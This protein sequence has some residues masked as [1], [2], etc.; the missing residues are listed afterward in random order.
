VFIRYPR[1]G[2]E[3]CSL[4]RSKLAIGLVH[5]VTL[6]VC[7]PNFTTMTFISS[8][9]SEVIAAAAD[10]CKTT[11][12]ENNTSSSSIANSNSAMGALHSV[13]WSFQRVTTG[14]G[15]DYNAN[16]SL[17]VAVPNEVIWNVDFKSTTASE[18][19][20]KSLNFWIQVNER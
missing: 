17:P 10:T 19:F 8:G 12:P 6:V 2:S 5:L 3:W 7:I 18:Q 15:E 16:D 11:M 13:T 14:V 9:S 4:A 20:M 1:H